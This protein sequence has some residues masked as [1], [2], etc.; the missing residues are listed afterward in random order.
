MARI[1]YARVSTRGQNLDSQLDMLRSAGCEKIFEDKESGCNRIRPG[2]TKLQEY[3]RPGDTIIIAEL[4]RMTR[5]LM[6]LLS[7]VEE[8]EKKEV[9]IVSLREHIDTTTATGRA[10]ISMIGAVNQMERDLKAERAAAGRASAKA[11]GKTGGRPRTDPVLLNQA[12]IL[13]ADPQYTA[14]KACTAVGV[15]RRTFFAYLKET[16]GDV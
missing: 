2:W 16:R 5:S 10:F 6:H 13:Y 12:K 9:Q 1:G 15:G 4:S 8:L 7:L 14:A 3:I 11:R